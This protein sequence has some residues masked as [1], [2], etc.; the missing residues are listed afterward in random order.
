[1]LPSLRRAVPLALIAAA[2]VPASAAATVTRSSVTAP[3]NPTYRL[4][5]PS[6]KAAAQTLRVAGTTDG[7]AGDL[8]D[9]TCGGTAVL[10]AVEVDNDGRFAAE[11]PYKTF[12]RLLCTLRAV[13]DKYNGKDLD[14]FT[15]PLV[16]ITYFN[17][18]ETTTA[19][20][21]AERDVPMDYSARTAHLGGPSDVSSIAG[22]ALQRTVW[23]LGAFVGT[24]DKDDSRRDRGRRPRRV[25]RGRRAAV[26]VRRR[27]ARGARRLRGRAVDADARRAHGR[28]RGAGIPAARALRPHRCPAAAPGG[29]PVRARHRRAARPDDHVHGRPRARRRPGPLDR[30]RRAGAPAAAR[31]RARH[32]GRAS[33]LA[34]CRRAGL[35][36]ARLSRRRRPQRRRQRPARHRRGDSARSATTPL[37]RCS[38][39]AAPACC[40]S[41]SS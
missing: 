9:L 22:G 29:L 23:G 40:P 31:L 1:M 14:P 4:Y 13:P 6:E 24:F 3:T 35:H 16:A 12:P 18:Y 2:L 17:P 33:A 8:V 27:A 5:L 38:R 30:H 39:S 20:L 34:L 15:G 41:W 19:V 36:A 28:R 21:G 26:R 7:A 37:R 25:R 11:V 32:E 10:R